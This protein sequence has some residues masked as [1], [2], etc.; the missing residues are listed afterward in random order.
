MKGV[1]GPLLGNLFC[2]ASKVMESSSTRIR[3]DHT[4]PYHTDSFALHIIC[5]AVLATC[6]NVQINLEG[7]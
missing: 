4:I 5:I 1:Q 6:P 2:K 3:H 7:Q